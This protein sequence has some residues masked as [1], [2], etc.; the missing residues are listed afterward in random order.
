MT[1]SVRPVVD[2]DA[3]DDYKKYLPK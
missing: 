1:Y 2:P 3:K